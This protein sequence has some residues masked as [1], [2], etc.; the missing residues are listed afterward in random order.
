MEDISINYNI[1]QI[2]L[3]GKLREKSNFVRKY[4]AREADNLTTS[5]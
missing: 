2:I 4:T 1:K 5:H 3:V